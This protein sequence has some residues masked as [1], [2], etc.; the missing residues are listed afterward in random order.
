M[1]IIVPA[2]PATEL[3][4]RFPEDKP[5]FMLYDYAGKSMLFRAVEPYL[6]KYKIHIGVLAEHE[7]KFNIKDFIQHEFGNLINLVIVPDQTSG[8]ADTVD[9]Q[10]SMASPIL[11]KDCD[12]FFKHEIVEGHYLCVST[13]N[14]KLTV[15][16]PVNKSYVSFNDTG[17]V[18]K[19]SEKRVLSDTY[20]TGGYKF[21][22]AHYFRTAVQDI[23]YSNLQENNEIFISDVV[24]YMLSANQPFF[25]VDTTD[26]I[27]IS[28]MYDWLEHNNKPVV[29]C[30]ID[31]TIIK[32]QQRYGVDNYDS[33]PVPLNNNVGTVLKM[34]DQGSQIIF[35]TSR[36]ESVRDITHQM[37]KSLGF[38]DFQLLMN[39]NDSA[40]I[41]INDYNELNPY[42]GATAI[43]IRRNSDN[44]GDFF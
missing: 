1:E 29:F 41:L 30:D 21:Q 12:S 28:T 18:Q 17:F 15:N 38:N 8:P 24:R 26:Y 20:C 36:P 14:K 42:P 40:R 19:I 16:S 39:L 11:V 22:Q 5:K 34:Q 13:F 4:T 27:D 2:V 9:A 6:T 25:I 7:Q 31:G 32:H 44:L 35:T 43:N 10:I 23:K 3:V 33:V 37:L